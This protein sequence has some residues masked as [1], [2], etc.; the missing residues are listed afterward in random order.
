MDQQDLGVL[1][2]SQG[3]PGML[4]ES[5]KAPLRCHLDPLCF[6]SMATATLRQKLL[7]CVALHSWHHPI[8]PILCSRVPGK[9]VQPVNRLH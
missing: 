3:E 9:S 2:A 6:T 7:T 8:I 1:L 4:N 5:T